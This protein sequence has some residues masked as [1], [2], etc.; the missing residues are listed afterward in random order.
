MIKD[1][2]IFES[3]QELKVGDNVIIKYEDSKYFMQTGQVMSIEK[4]GD[5]NIRLDYTGDIV[6]FYKTKFQLFTFK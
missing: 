2:K 6:V 1:F 3:K 5:C 4:T